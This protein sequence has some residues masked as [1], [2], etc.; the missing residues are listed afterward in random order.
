MPAAHLARSAAGLLVAGRWRLR[1]C[2]ARDGHAAEKTV[3]PLFSGVGSYRARGDLAG[4]VG[5][6]GSG[7]DGLVR[8]HCVPVSPLPHAVKGNREDTVRQV[9]LRAG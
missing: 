1:G 4:S 9:D 5:G 8:A 7:C 2:S 6:Q 3:I